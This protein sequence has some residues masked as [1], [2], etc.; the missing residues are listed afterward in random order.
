MTRQYIRSC[1]EVEVIVIEVGRLV[2]VMFGGAVGLSVQYKPADN[3][4]SD[5]VDEATRTRNMAVF[6]EG[7]GVSVVVLSGRVVSKWR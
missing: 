6:V 3:Q 4:L 1:Q 2:N 7:I 5:V